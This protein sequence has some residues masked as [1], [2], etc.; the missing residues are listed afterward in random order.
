MVDYLSPQ[1]ITDVVA[2]GIFAQAEYDSDFNSNLGS[3]AHVDVES[4]G[5]SFV[6]HFKPTFGSIFTANAEQVAVLNSAQGMLHWTSPRAHQAHTSFNIPEFEGDVPYSPSLFAAA[7]TLHG[8][9]PALYAPQ[10]NG[11]TP[12]LVL[13]TPPPTP[14]SRR[15]LTHGIPYLLPTMN[16]RR[17]L[18][19]YA[20]ATGLGI[21]ETDTTISFSDGTDLTLEDNLIK[22]ISGDFSLDDFRADAFYFNVEQQL[23]F[24]ALYPNSPATP[25]AQF[26]PVTSLLTLFYGAGNSTRRHLDLGVGK[27]PAPAPAAG[28]P[29]AP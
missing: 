18:R 9:R 20:A 16:I 8:N 7:R 12:V 23:L 6:V 22:C 15:A 21:Y 24:D 14:N 10:R 4:A 26:D 3:I 28:Q 17:A 5:D 29:E 1:T 27:Q 2:D 13:D 25:T 19:A 11:E